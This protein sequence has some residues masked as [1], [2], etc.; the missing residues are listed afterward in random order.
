VFRSSTSNDSSKQ[1]PGPGNRSELEL[2]LILS[3]M[4][5]KPMQQRR[6]CSTI[7]A[8]RGNQNQTG[9]QY[10]RQKRVRA[11]L[12]RA[13]ASHDGQCMDKTGAR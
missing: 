1:I 13:R 6:A 10:G 11:H 3:Q 8:D 2:E 12:M 4:A 5:Q 7:F 9:G